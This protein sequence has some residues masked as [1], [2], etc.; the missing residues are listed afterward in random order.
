[1]NALK[2][3]SSRRYG[4]AGHKKT[5][6]VKLVGGIELLTQLNNA[7]DDDESDAA[8]FA[9]VDVCVIQLVASSVF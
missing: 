4:Q 7:Q 1:V 6:V 5:S 9:S 3:V 8:Q 2:G